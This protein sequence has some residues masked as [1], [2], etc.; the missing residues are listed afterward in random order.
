MGVLEMFVQKHTFGLVLSDSLLQRLRRLANVY[1]LTYIT[2][3][4]VNYTLRCAVT[5][6]TVSTDLTRS[7]SG[8]ADPVI[9]SIPN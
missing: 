8:V 3:N 5:H 1:L 4:L 6:V 9:N 2:L 7:A